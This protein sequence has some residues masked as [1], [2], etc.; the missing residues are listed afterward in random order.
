MEVTIKRNAFRKLSHCA[1][2]IMNLSQRNLGKLRYS[3]TFTFSAMF[4]E[5]SFVSK[6]SCT[7]EPNRTNTP[8]YSL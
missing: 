4:V 2:V 6:C 8:S 1:A 3:I 7:C 5:I